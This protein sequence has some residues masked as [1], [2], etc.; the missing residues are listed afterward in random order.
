MP[1]TGQ[2]H[3]R[4]MVDGRMPRSKMG[5]LGGGTLTVRLKVWDQ[6]GD[7]VRGS[8]NLGQLWDVAPAAATT[9]AAVWTISMESHPW[10]LRPEGGPP[11]SHSSAPP[12][13]ITNIS[14]TSIWDLKNSK[15]SYSHLCMSLLDLKS[16]ML[17]DLHMIRLTR[18][19]CIN[20]KRSNA[21]NY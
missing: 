16:N 5:A 21:I 1:S 7:P 12:S 8:W 18:V 9:T 17:P 15:I 19:N 4:L 6:S 20:K 13:P 14:P 10:F 3:S 2:Q 11:A